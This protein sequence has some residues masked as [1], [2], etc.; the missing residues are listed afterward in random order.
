CPDG[1][2]TAECQKPS[3]CSGA[4]SACCIT[5]AN[6]APTKVACEAP[7]SC[8]PA[9]MINGSGSDRACVTTADCTGNGTNGTTL[10]DCCLS[11]ATGQ[12]ICFSKTLAMSS[13]QLM[14]AFNCP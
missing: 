2:F 14:A 10:P 3:D 7:A 4:M 11:T 8:V 12:H 13:A 1:G 9:L 6:Y 5:V